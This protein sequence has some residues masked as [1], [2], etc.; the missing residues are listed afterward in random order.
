MRHRPSAVGRGRRGLV[1]EVHR[2]LAVVQVLEGTAGDRSRAGARR[3]SRDAPSRSRSGRSGSG[4]CGT[5]WASRSTAVRR[6]SVATCGPSPARRSTRPCA[7]CRAIRSS[8]ACRS[9]TPSPR[10]SAAR[11][12]RCSPSAGLPHLELAAQIAAQANAGG[13]PFTVVVAAMG[14]THAD[15]AAVR[16]ALEARGGERRAGPVPRHGRRPGRPADPHAACGAHRRR[17]PRVRARPA[18]AGGAGRHDELLRGCARG[19]GGPRRDPRAPG[20]SR[21]TS[22]AIWPRSTS[23]AAA[24]AGGPGPS[25]RSRSSPCPPATSPTRYRT[26][27][28]TSPRARSCSRPSSTAPAS[29]RRSTCSGRCPG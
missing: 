2:D 10:W 29:T 15:A 14:L 27:P 20:L 13:E 7:T 12:C 8:P 11:S 21:A 16:D 17:A 3:A 19:L 4:G 6:C 26:S 28:A 9:S 1:L 5:G 18:R 22:T 25:R 23:A 24:S